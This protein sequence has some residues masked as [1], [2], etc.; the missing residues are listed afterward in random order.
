MDDSK[1]QLK[2]SEKR[3]E[4]KR[5]HKDLDRGF[6]ASDADL[7]LVSKRPP[8]V[9]AYLDYKGSGEPVTF[10]EAILYNVWMTY[11]PVFIVEGPAASGPFKIKRYKGA[12]WKP[13]IADVTWGNEE[14][15]A[16]WAAFGEWER[17][18]RDCYRT[19][20]GWGKFLGGHSEVTA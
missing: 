15:A 13:R 5:R 16:T 18:L 9:V 12:D 1:R 17:R 2:G 4:F 19:N 11:A 10:T 7:C 20:G 3:D 6:Y 14:V 8:G